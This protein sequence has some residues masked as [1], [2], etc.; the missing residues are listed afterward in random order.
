MAFEDAGLLHLYLALTPENLDAA[1]GTIRR[2]LN[3]LA[4]REVTASEL[5]EAKRYTIG[6]SRIALEN[7]ASQMIW[8]G[9]C[10]LSFGEVK[11]PD[12]VHQ[13]LAAVTPRNILELA[14]TLF[15]QERLVVSAV[16]PDRTEERLREWRGDF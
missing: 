12:S 8:A 9:E 4:A 16:G 6:Q 15:R 13:K 2:I 3:Q 5:E 7:T 1:L 11:D 14:R 10:L